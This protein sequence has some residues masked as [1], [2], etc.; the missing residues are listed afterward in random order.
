VERHLSLVAKTQYCVV[1]VSRGGWW[2]K[3]LLPPPAPPTFSLIVRRARA[4]VTGRECS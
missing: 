1:L 2:Q 4:A 3:S